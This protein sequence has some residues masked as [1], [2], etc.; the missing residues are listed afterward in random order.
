[1]GGAGGFEIAEIA[2][3]FADTAA[4]DRQVSQRLRGV[5]DRLAQPAEEI[6]ALAT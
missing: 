5:A 6:E 2:L 4:R 3:D 1:M